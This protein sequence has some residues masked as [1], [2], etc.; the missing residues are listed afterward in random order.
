MII[1]LPWPPSNNVYYRH[2]AR[3]RG[4]M[5]YISPKG[6]EFKAEVRYLLQGAV[7]FG[8]ARL[9]VIVTCHAP[10]KRKYDVD[11]YAKAMLDSIKGHLFNDDDQID[12]LVLQRGAVEGKPGKLVV[13]INE[14]Q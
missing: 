12:R 8:D 10:T 11:N 9:E 4:V 5:V 2:A 7:T 1:G 14:I 3:G 6:M 13:E